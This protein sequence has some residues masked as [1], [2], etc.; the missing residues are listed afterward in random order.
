[1]T[2]SSG[3]SEQAPRFASTHAHTHAS[4]RARAYHQRPAYPPGKTRPMRS[5]LHTHTHTHA[6]NHG[7]HTH[8]H[9]FIG[10]PRTPKLPPNHEVIRAVM[11]EGSLCLIVCIWSSPL[12]HAP[13][14]PP[15]LETHPLH[16][17]TS[18]RVVSPPPAESLTPLPP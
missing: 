5:C 17:H 4:A 9:V 6:S 16:T 8:Q 10:A 2:V 15:S 14:P 1:M 18:T 12:R 3:A 11:L 7:A 13:P